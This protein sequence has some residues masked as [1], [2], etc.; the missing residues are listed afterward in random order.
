MRAH[1]CL[2]HRHYQRIADGLEQTL[3]MLPRDERS[4]RLRMHIEIAIETATEL[5]YTRQ[6]GLTLV[7]SR[8]GI[9]G[10]ERERDA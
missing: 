2:P 6:S 7:Y 8:S 9:A 1:E 5:A 3:A 4:A 10:K